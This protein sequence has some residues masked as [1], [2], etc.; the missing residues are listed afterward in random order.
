[1]VLSIDG[2][3][4]QTSGPFAVGAAPEMMGGVLAVAA[5]DEER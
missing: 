4:G 2:G 5:K 3:E 1:M